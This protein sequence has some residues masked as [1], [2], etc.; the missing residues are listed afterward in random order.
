MASNSES[1]YQRL[2]RE[3]QTYLTSL[4]PPN[5]DWP[6]DVRAVAEAIHH[7]LFNLDLKLKDVYRQCGIGNHNVS[8][9]FK[10]FTGR[11]PKDYVVHHRILLAKRLLQTL[12]IEVQQIALTVGY[13]SPSAFTKAFKKHFGCTPTQYKRQ[14][15]YKR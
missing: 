3:R 15:G 5:P 4:S 7:Q 12:D 6:S 14:K 11:A 1:I 9:R 10:H 8:A 2:E 13:G